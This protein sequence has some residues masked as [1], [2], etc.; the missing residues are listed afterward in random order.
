M[1]PTHS[2][3]SDP[4]QSAKPSLHTLYRKPLLDLGVTGNED[5]RG[6]Y[7]PG[8]D[9]ETVGRYVQSQFIQDADVYAT[10]YT[11]T[12]YWRCLIERAFV[13]AGID[14]LAG[15]VI[16]DLG[17]GA[18]NTIFP[19]LELCPQSL[20]IASDLSVKML[21]LLKRALPE[22]RTAERIAI[23]ELNAEDLDFHPE[24]FDLVVGG[25]IL[26]HLLSPE[27]T[28][29][30]CSRILKPGGHAIFF[31]PFE[32]GNA[33]LA[34]IYNIIANYPLEGLPPDVLNFLRHFVQDLDIRKGR[35]KSAP[36]FGRLDDKWCFTRRYFEE[37]STRFG[38]SQCTIYPLLKTEGQFEHQTE[39]YLRLGLNRTRDDFPDWAWEMVRQL[40]SG[41]SEDLKTDMLIEG[42]IILRK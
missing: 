34:R 35:D 12:S 33:I 7:S 29:E 20:V 31:E 39:I 3:S 13:V 40:D 8:Y 11:N 10:R 38:F 4:A 5:L 41:F 15:E 28:L 21:A 9:P 26:H 23:L 32:N 14:P 2:S 42:C 24:S 17:S 37:F 18:G 1:N 30:G 6:I 36:I 16:L 27:R 22:T 25:A 19:L